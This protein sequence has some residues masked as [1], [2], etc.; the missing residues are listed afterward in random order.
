MIRAYEKYKRTN[1]IKYITVGIIVVLMGSILFTIN[2]LKN[3]R[4]N[5]IL[6]ISFQSQ[7]FD[8]SVKENITSDKEINNIE[9]TV[10]TV[11]DSN[12]LAPIKVDYYNILIQDLEKLRSGDKDIVTKYFGNSDSITPEIIA[13]R[14]KATR[15]NFI[16]DEFNEDNNEIIN[17]HICTIN[18]TNMNNDFKYTKDIFISNGEDEQSAITKA[19]E[20]IAKCL[21][22]NKYKQC[23]NIPITIKDN[24]IVIS[25]SFKQAIT[26]G[27][28]NGINVELIP[29]ECPIV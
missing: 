15:I 16:S 3:Q 25:E 8:K 7:T 17:I 28:Y 12:E 27:W 10:R 9:Y 22:E 13:D 4:E 20:E 6:A 26:G 5:S 18:Y 1:R 24:D 11:L 21:L 19:T 29:V 14:V 2:N 23:F